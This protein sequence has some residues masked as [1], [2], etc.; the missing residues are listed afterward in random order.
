MIP[1]QFPDQ[2]QAST[3]FTHVHMKMFWR[4]VILK[5]GGGGSEM[6]QIKHFVIQGCELEFNP[7]NPCKQKVRNDSKVVL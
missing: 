4:Q 7:Q 5:P 3:L 2:P 1:G 6:T